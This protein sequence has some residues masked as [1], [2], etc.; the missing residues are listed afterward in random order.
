[1]VVT[2]TCTCKPNMVGTNCKCDCKLQFVWD[3]TISGRSRNFEKGVQRGQLNGRGF[4]TPIN[5]NVC[6]VTSIRA[7]LLADIHV[8]YRLVHFAVR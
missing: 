6:L 5:Y 1:M 2:C 3:S 8:L 7:L 4:T